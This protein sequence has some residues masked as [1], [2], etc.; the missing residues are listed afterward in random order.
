MKHYYDASKLDSVVV[1][2][3]DHKVVLFHILE[4]QVWVEFQ[5]YILEEFQFLVESLFL[6]DKLEYQSLKGH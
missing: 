3:V 4:Y 6:E 5:F 1:H 2:L